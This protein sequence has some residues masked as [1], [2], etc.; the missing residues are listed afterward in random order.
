MRM[1]WASAIC[2]P[3]IMLLN[4][5]RAAMPATIPTT[6][7]DAS[8]LAPTCRAPGKVMSMS[9]MPA[10]TTPVM[11]VRESTRAW[12]AMRRAARLSSTSAGCWAMTPLARPPMAAISSQQAPAMTAR[13]LRW[14]TPPM[15]GSSSLAAC[16]TSCSAISGSKTRMTGMHAS[17]T[18]CTTGKGD[19]A[20][21]RMRATMRWAMAASVMANKATTAV[22]GQGE[23]CRLSSMGAKRGQTATIAPLKACICQTS[24][25]AGQ[26][27]SAR[28]GA[29]H[30]SGYSFAGG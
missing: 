25:R 26:L 22:A 13:P 8:R 3:A 18:F 6:P 17:T 4:T 30:P 19:V 12:V 27:F 29:R 9:A 23:S 28:W 21:R 10:M 16:H 1:G 11:A 20:R 2:R 14:R 5:G 15:A 24:C 7:A